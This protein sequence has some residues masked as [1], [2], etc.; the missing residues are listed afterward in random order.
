[1]APFY[2]KLGDQGDT[3]I[4]GPGRVSKSSLRIEA[5]G[6]LD[7][8]SSALGFARALAASEKT[9]NILLQT[10]KTLYVLMSEVSAL[11]S[12]AHQFDKLGQEDVAWLENQISELEA[13]VELPRDFILPGTN[14]ASSALSLAR[15]I[16]RRAERRV[17]ALFEAGEINK[18][19]IIAY[20]NRLS[21]LIFTLE[22]YE[23]NISD[24]IIQLAKEG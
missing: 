9:K 15:T 8:A 12:T 2:T 13:Q 23:I 18:S 22:I 24:G 1:M 10:Q 6:S 11:P 21:S 14:P 16:V 4:L 17:I 7:E 3:G 20:L 5:V 19:T